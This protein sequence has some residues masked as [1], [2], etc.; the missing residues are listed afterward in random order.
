MNLHDVNGE[1]KE[2]EEDTGDQPIEFPQCLIDK[3]CSSILFYSNFSVE[4][5]RAYVHNKIGSWGDHFCISHEVA[6]V[7][8]HK[9]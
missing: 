7:F 4:L 8:S 5:L 3:S 1:K 2:E 6:N 9:R